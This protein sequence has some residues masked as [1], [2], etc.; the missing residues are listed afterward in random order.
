MP[1]ALLTPG[2]A[3][4]RAGRA[5]GVAWIVG[6][7]AV[8]LHPS[9]AAAQALADPQVPRGRV[10]FDFVPSVSSW[11]ARYGRWMD[12]ST[13]VDGVEALGDDFTDPRGVALFPGV[14]TLEEALR[15]LTGDAGFEGAIG[16]T[17]GR[18]SKEVTRLDMGARIGLFDWLTVGVNVPYVKGRTTLDLAYRPDAG[19]NLGINP[20][21]SGGGNV[22]GL[23]TGLGDAAVAASSRA[24]A[25]CAGGSSPACQS[26]TALSRQANDFWQGLLKA[27]F[28][29]PFFPLG[30]S[31][32]AGQLQSSLA[33]L[34]G[35]LLAAGLPGVGSS[36][37]FATAAVDQE[38]FGSLPTEAGFG[39]AGSPL[40]GVDGIW[41][42]G[43]IEVNANVRLLEGERRDSGAVSPRYAYG[44]Y[45][46]FL[47]R[48]ATG[49]L[50]DPDVFL[51]IGSGDGQMDMEGRLDAV[52]RFGSRVDLRGGFR[53]GTQQAVDVVR[54]VAPHEAV[55]PLAATRAAVTWTPGSYSLVEVSPRLHMGEALAFA[56][57]F[58]RFHKSADSYALLGEGT[59]VP[60]SDPSLLAQETEVTLQ[61]LGLGL[62]YSS[63]GLWRQGRVGTPAEMGIR[64]IRPLS[65][66]GGQTPKASRVELSV[67]LFRHIWG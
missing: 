37:A 5:F 43:D 2:S 53:Y 62:R 64:L 25:V 36:M 39:I 29:S 6:L 51:D 21:L 7:G 58:R 52:L 40:R 12:G 22:G 11:D 50:D 23:L 32:V 46:G 42:L 41:Q 54:R 30:G 48:L 67:S 57:D 35:A 31:P 15:S 61:E 27:Y 55:L 34:D 18:L 8:G 13:P 28:A 17:V 10:R 26:A 4:R 14:T 9:P 56:L 16:S 66:S 65:G 38:T 20:A 33:T 3:L 1:N 24:E 44:L 59:G 63:R 47:V 49:K 45:G 19:A 60:P